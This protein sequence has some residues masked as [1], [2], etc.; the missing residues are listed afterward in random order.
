MVLQGIAFLL[1]FLLLLVS[2][3]EPGSIYGTRGSLRL[4][5]VVTGL[6]I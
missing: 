1:L 2:A 3:G 4:L 5:G 6:V